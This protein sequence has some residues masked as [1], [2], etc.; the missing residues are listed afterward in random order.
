MIV[1]PAMDIIDGSCVRLRMGDYA[2]KQVYA[3]D[4]VE[5]AKQFADHGLRRLH[6]VDLD[7]ARAKRVVNI[8]VLKRILSSVDLVIDV[9]GGL[10]TKED[11]QAVFSAGAA[12][13]TVGSL[14]ARDRSLTLELLDA[15]GPQRL[16]LGADCREGSIAVSGWEKTTGIPVVEFVAGYLGAGFSKVIST[17]IS[18]DGMM[19]GPS[20]SLY[21][22]LMSAMDARGLHIELIA[23]GGVSS[24]GDLD[25]LKEAGLSGA[26]VGK[27][28][29]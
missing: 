11:F 24:L 26:I 22:T 3:T 29:Y 21:R 27:A 9:G 18:K 20:I 1:I 12:M 19:E 6:L 5:V 2:T 10:H 25:E 17:D 14:A 23:S 7:G 13:A 16:I 15:W 28:L 8:D 4:P